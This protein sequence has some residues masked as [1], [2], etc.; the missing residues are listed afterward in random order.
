MISVVI[1]VLNE[2]DNVTLLLGEISRVAERAPISEIIFIDD[3]STDKTHAILSSM[4]TTEPRLRILRHEKRSGQS[5]A[6]WTGIR[7]AN[8][9]VIVTLDGDCQNDPADIEKLY[10]LFDQKG[11][12]SVALMVAG[13]RAK[14]RDNFIRRISSRSA[15]RFRS[16]LLKDKTKD[17][18]CSLKMFRRT[19]YMSLPYFNHMHRFIPALMMREGVEIVHVD[20]SHRPRTQGTSKYGTL[21][22]L[23]VSISDIAGVVW[24]MRRARPKVKV[25][26]DL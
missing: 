20:V 17:T 8:Q 19:D 22:R 14:R 10:K 21:D 11:G 3:G 12:K 25:F 1:P 18:G 15:N 2:Q 23:I 16:W 13:E 4:R 7:A 6:L 5:A 24:L 26:E 9:D